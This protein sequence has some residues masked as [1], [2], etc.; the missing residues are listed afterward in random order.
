MRSEILFI[1]GTDTGVGK[2]IVTATLAWVLR[3]NDCAVAALKPICS[4]GRADARLIRRLA[5]TKLPLDTVN[6]W[7]FRAPIAPVLAA[8]AERRRVTGREVVAHIKRV[9]KRFPVTLVEGAGGLL[10]PL[11]ED[12][13]SRDLIVALEATPIIVCPNQLGA[14][15]Q[16]LLVLAALPKKFAAR[17]GI[18]LVT[19]P[20]PDRASRSNQALLAERLGP[21]R[22]LEFPWLSERSRR[23]KN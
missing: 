23:Q 15:N 3:Q 10:S 9:A 14:V 13:D 4:G 5:G 11:G 12:F 1:T 18:V 8:R 16:V 20:R 19:Q 21:D 6:P 2:T 17:A 7:H 22:I